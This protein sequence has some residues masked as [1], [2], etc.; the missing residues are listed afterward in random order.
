MKYKE[1]DKINGITIL[2]RAP[3][4]GG[5][6]M[7][8]CL[9]HCGNLFKT[10]QSHLHSGHT[11]SCGCIL[12][13]TSKILHTTHGKT[14]TRLRRIWNS[15]KQ[16]CYNNNIPQYKDWGGRGI[17]VCDEWR[18]DFQAFY[19]WSMANGYDDNLSIDRIDNDGNYEPNNCQWATRKQQARNKRNNVYIT[20]KGVSKTANE[21]A[22]YLGVN[23]NSFKNRISRKW[24]IDKIF[25]QPY[26][27]RHECT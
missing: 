5:K 25:N 18:D 16:R 12:K 14:E 11:I 22:E 6:T 27:R 17:A 10:S 13:Y 26:R 24:D 15:M 19:D 20:Y 23:P 9:C 7:Y 3:N 8:Y 2:T 1:L 21:W 4:K